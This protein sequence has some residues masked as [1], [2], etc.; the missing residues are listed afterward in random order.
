VRFLLDIGV[1]QI[2]RHEQMLVK[3]FL[4]RAAEIPALNVYGP[5]EVNQRVGLLSFNVAGVSPSKVGLILD[6]AFGIMTRVGLH[7][8][9]AAHRTL[10]TYPEGTVRFGFS[11]FNTLAEVD[12]AVETLTRLAYEARHGC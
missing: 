4:G 6:Q 8:A 5:V 3:R 10:D 7:C 9:P 11:Y 1:E 12:Q 2:C